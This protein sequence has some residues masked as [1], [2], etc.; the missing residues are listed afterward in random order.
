[1][2]VPF[3]HAFYEFSYEKLIEALGFAALLS[4]A[5]LIAAQ[6]FWNRVKNRIYLYV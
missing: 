4:A 2:I 5:L 1:L 3:R 6:L